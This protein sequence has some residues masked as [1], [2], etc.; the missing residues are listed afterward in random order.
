[1]KPRP[2]SLRMKKRY[3]L[4]RIVPPWR[5]PD[6]RTLS[7][8]VHEAATSLW[9]DAAT[10][11]MQPSVVVAERDLFIVRCRRGTEK[12]LLTAL[13]TVIIVN[14]EPVALRTLATSGTMLG[15]RHKSTRYYQEVREEE[16]IW[17]NQPTRMYRYQGQKVDLLERGIKGQ[18]V[19]FLTEEDIEEL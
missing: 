6:A 14:D 17:K 15:L 4:G 19:V 9:G 5:N 2:P 12:D 13:S 3:V 11:R 1:M 10:S 18:N 7:T 8:A 16:R